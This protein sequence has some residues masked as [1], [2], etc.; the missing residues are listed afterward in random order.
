[1]AQIFARNEKEDFMKIVN[2]SFR[3]GYITD[4][5][6]NALISKYERTQ[7]NE[8]LTIQDRNAL[9]SLRN[10]ILNYQSEVIENATSALKFENLLELL[11]FVDKGPGIY[12]HLCKTALLVDK[13]VSSWNVGKNYELIL[14]QKPGKV[15]SNKICQNTSFSL[16]VEKFEDELINAVEKQLRSIR[17]TKPEELDLKKCPQCRSDTLEAKHKGEAYKYRQGLYHIKIK[18]VPL[19]AY[20]TLCHYQEI[21]ETVN[22]ELDK[23][24]K[25]LDTKTLE[26]L[27]L[28]G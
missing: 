16:D 25:I 28:D 22:N 4:K 13:F 10:S 6:R 14:E 23:L 1:M 26:L 27:K 19:K 21:G 17:T 24:Q 9:R 5:Q 20:C 3:N 2:E 12:C 15:C 11:S 7:N 18:D 8:P